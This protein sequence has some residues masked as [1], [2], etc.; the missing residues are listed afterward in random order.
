[1]AEMHGAR[2]YPWIVKVDRLPFWT[3]S[4][5]VMCGQHMHAT[6]AADHDR[7]EYARPVLA[8]GFALLPTRLLRLIGG[9]WV[10]PRPPELA[11]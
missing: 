6:C 5:M 10:L 8:S 2:L 3:Q 7:T 9:R 4:R 1:M 11:P